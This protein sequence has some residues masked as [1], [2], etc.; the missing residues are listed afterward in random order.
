MARPERSSSQ[1]SLFMDTEYIIPPEASIR[2]RVI[3]IE[4]IIDNFIDP[5]SYLSKKEEE[6]TKEIAAI[7]K[8]MDPE[9]GE[10]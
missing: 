8:M 7:T 5:T 1:L 3:M 6:R 2:R 4:T 10:P 9:S